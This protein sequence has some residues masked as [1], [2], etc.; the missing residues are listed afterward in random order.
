[1]AGQAAHRQGCQQAL[2]Y[3]P[4]IHTR[5]NRHDPAHTFAAI[6]HAGIGIHAQFTAVA[7]Q[8][9]QGVQHIA[10]IEARGLHR[11]FQFPGTRRPSLQWH[12]P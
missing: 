8:Q 12:G 9:S 5:A 11:K 10:E 1:M 3:Q 2:T 7:R 6:G 4:R